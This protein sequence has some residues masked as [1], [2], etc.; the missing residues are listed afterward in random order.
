MQSA[1]INNG[2]PRV[3]ID[4][5]QTVYAATATQ[6]NLYLFRH[7]F[8]GT[9][10]FLTFPFRRNDTLRVKFD[11]VLGANSDKVAAIANK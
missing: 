6:C 7:H 10:A 2:E 4:G 11:E 9:N 5:E 1:Q 3:L 8:E